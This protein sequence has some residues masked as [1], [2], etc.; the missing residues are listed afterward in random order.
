MTHFFNF[1][2]EKIFD[3]LNFLSSVKLNNKQSAI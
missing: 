2:I 1:L 3:L